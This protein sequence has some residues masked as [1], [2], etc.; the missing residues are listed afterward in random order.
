MRRFLLLSFVAAAACS[1]EAPKPAVTEAPKPV[2]EAPKP[3]TEAEALAVANALPPLMIAKD[4]PGVVALYA[5]NAVLVDPMSPELVTTKEANLA[6]TKGLI[7]MN[8]TKMIVHDRKVQV[9]DADTF[10]VTLIGSF[11]MQPPKGKAETMTMRVTD[12]YQ[13]QADGKWLA[14][15]EH[16][17]AMPAKPK[18]PLPVIE[19]FPPAPASPAPASPAPASASPAAKPH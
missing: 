19:T 11:V 12:V 7:D 3:P 1:P 15:N 2:V 9:L 6:A 8:M 13:K 5:D 4:A 14:V 10:V 18:S 17:S 16:V